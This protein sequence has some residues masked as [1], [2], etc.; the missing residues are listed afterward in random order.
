MRRG[1]VLLLSVGVQPLVHRVQRLS[2]EKQLP[3]DLG[4]RHLQ[5]QLGLRK[6]LSRLRDMQDLRAERKL[7]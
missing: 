5:Q 3:G 6:I 1:R 7:G 2:N 4:L